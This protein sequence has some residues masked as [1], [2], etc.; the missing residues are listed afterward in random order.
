MGNSKRLKVI[1]TTF[2]VLVTVIILCGVYT[3][4]NYIYMQN[5]KKEI[6]NIL[7]MQVDREASIISYKI[8]NVDDTALDIADIIT[9]MPLYDDKIVNDQIIKKL[10]ADR[11]LFGIGVW[12]EPYT[13]NKKMKYYGPYIYRNQDEKVY[14]TYAYSTPSYNYFNQDWYKSAF[15]PARKQIYYSKA[16]YDSILNTYFITGSSPIIEN[17]KIIGVTT[18]DTALRGIIQYIDTIKVGENGHAFLLT[19]MGFLEENQ[20]FS[21]TVRINKEMN[22]RYT[23]LINKVTS[24]TNT[25]IMDLKKT[26]QIAAFTN[27]GETGMKLV[28]I[29]SKNEL[30]NTANKTSILFFT[31]FVLSMIFL[32]MILSYI[33]TKFIDKP[34]N[35]LLMKVNKITKGDLSQDK[36]LDSV[37]YENYEFGVLAKSIIT[38]SE[39]LD[40]VIS[41]L[42]IQN[43]VLAESKKR[44]VNS[45]ESYRLIFEASNEGL[46]ELNLIT[47]VIYFSDRWHEIFDNKFNRQDINTTENW[48]KMMHPDDYENVKRIFDNVALGLNDMFNCEFR[49]LGRD[50]KY[51]WILNRAKSLKDNNGKP[52][53]LAGSHTDITQRKLDEEKIKN[54]AYYDVLTELPNRVHFIDIMSDMILKGMNENNKF[55]VLFM[56]IDSFKLINDSFGHTIGDKVLIHVAERFKKITNKDVVISRI[57]GDEFTI[58]IDNITARN[59]ALEIANQIHS[60]LFEPFYI[61]ERVFYLSTSIGISIYPD[62]GETADELLKDA[63]TAMYNAKEEGKGKSMFFDKKMNDAIMKKT[64]IETGIR[65]GIKNEEFILYYQP[66]FDMKNNK[67]IG[68]EALVRWKT[69][70]KGII[71]PI[72]FIKIAEDTKLIIPLGNWIIRSVCSYARKL[73]DLGYRDFKV[74]INVSV[75]QLMEDDFSLIVSSAI[76]EMKIPFDCIEIEITE[77]E[78]MESYDACINNM[79]DLTNKGVKFAIDDFGTGYSSLYYLK[80]LPIS[81]IKIDKSFVDDLSHSKSKNFIEFII[82]LSRTLGLK[83]IAEGV[84]RKQQFDILKDYG[85]DIIQGYYISKPLPEKEAIKL[86]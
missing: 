40:H 2:I 58:I 49:L 63:D 16:F 59:D 8:N 84:E 62:D 52:Y 51:F 38:M 76:E 9:S 56:D 13:Y 61:E 5:N 67:I 47:S 3:V 17:N 29:Y 34:L 77:S 70:D 20:G 6:E 72:N 27:I 64:E 15:N 21:K 30:Y 44:I 86:L 73:I 25:Q 10:N 28:L 26:N 22:K 50:G 46:W 12:F 55:A 35:L 81:I 79:I 66:F 36:I 75:I 45:E 32:I 60:L 54:L 85:C 41:S 65:R 39:N 53:R 7:S 48:F 57:G 80:Q 83:V 74:S 31:V 69:P 23:D 68:F 1:I 4:T 11:M 18:A 43:N 82:E 19:N 24:T 14:T 78:L 37:I 71:L 33:F 42:N